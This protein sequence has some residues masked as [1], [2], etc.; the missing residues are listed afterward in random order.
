MRLTRRAFTLLE[1]LASIA[2]IAML[3][4]IV[5]VSLRG[6]RASATRS[7]SM[8]AVR[9]MSLAYSAYSGENNLFLMP[10]YIEQGDFAN[11]P[12]D[13]LEVTGPDGLALDP[14][15][16]QSY[17]WR[18]APYLDDAWMTYFT[19]MTESGARSKFSEDFSAGTYGPAGSPAYAGGISERPSYG[20]N[21]LFVG[22]DSGHTTVR[23]L[24]PWV[25]GPDTIAATRLS[26][27]KSP[28]RLIV[29]GPAARGG[30]DPDLVYEEPEVGYCELRAPYI[31]LTGT[32]AS[33]K[34]TN[35][36]W[37]VGQGGLVEPSSSGSLDNDGGFPIDRAGKDVIPVA[38]LDGSATVVEIGKLSRD[39]R[40]WSPFEITL[41]ETG[42]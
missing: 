42:P 27:V 1:L 15:D 11:P 40:R 29:F 38:H 18:L 31:E 10:G 41:R 36:Q 25:A 6:V 39:M 23:N 26:Q 30:D 2:V 16:A 4:G 13:K 5:L 8:S 12:F 22:G 3:M 35:Q 33:A 19:D 32:G 17:V 9:Q 24:N 21:S 14:A 37:S 34:W 7:R 20:M 28:A